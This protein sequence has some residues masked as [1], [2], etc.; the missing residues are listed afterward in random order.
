MYLVYA[1]ST[2]DVTKD[3]LDH[4]TFVCYDRNKCANDLQPSTYVL[5]RQ[6]V[7]FE[8][9][10][11]TFS[12]K[13]IWAE[14]VAIIMRAFNSRCVLLSDVF[15]CPNTTLYRCAHSTKCISVHRLIDGIVDCEE[16]DDETFEDSCSL[17]DVTTRFRCSQENKCLSQPLV[18]NGVKDC[19]GGD[20]EIYPDLRLSRHLISFTTMCDGFQELEPILIHDQNG[21]NEKGCAH[22]RCNNTYTHC[23]VIWNCED[24]I[25]EI[26]C[27]DY[28]L[29]YP[30][31]HHHCVDWT[32]AQLICLPLSM[33]NDGHVDCLGGFDEMHYCRKV[34]TQV[35]PLHEPN[36]CGYQIV[37]IGF[38]C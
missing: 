33:A 37:Q 3:V 12:F 13:H 24:G 16:G 15:Q 7:H 30:P 14:K 22:W 18:N 21:T 8:R 25:D 2:V 6:C 4:P 26:G 10:N 29:R 5:D 20:D 38:R 28:S 27:V 31:L 11:I 9:L 36:T 19:K 17:T 1:R 32:T 35:C 23:D 34:K